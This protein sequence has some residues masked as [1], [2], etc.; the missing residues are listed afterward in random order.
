MNTN[1]GT[2]RPLVT[3]ATS[4]VLVAALLAGC[5][6]N[7]SGSPA[8][9]VT[10]APA[11]APVAASFA[12]A[13]A[14]L[15]TSGTPDGS[16][17]IDTTGTCGV[18]TAEAVST[19]ARFTVAY[20]SGAAGVC[21]YQSSDRAHNMG[22]QVYDSQDAMV[23]VLGIESEGTHI[24]GLGDDAFWVAQAGIFFARKGDHAIQFSDAEL[25][26]DSTNTAT[27]DALVTL[28]KMGLSNI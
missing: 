13:S 4:L 19:A 25:A 28:A 18:V 3:T 14:P 17:A 1:L 12:P 9:V 10:Q 8:P 23:A 22:V 6:G 7:S 2:R 21:I 11:S 20:A 24:S 27:R 5:G 16:S 15:A 26:T